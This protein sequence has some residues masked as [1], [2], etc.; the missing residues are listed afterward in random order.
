M[1]QNDG[2][3]RTT[4]VHEDVDVSIHD[5]NFVPIDIDLQSLRIEGG[6]IAHP[7]GT[8]LSLWRN[9]KAFIAHARMDCVGRRREERSY[10]TEEIYYHRVKPE[11][12]KIPSRELFPCYVSR[13]GFSGWSRLTG[14]KIRRKARS[15]LSSPLRRSTR[16]Y[17][18]VALRCVARRRN[19]VWL[20]RLNCPK[21]VRARRVPIRS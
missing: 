6:R 4:V 21:N 7:R 2:R 12:S 19:F 11:M 18:C 9:E 13:G 3:H 17:S 5:A 1:I 10:I 20:R 14:R 15:A 8:S 16:L